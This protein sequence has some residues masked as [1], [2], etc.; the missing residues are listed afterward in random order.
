MF[1]E[2]EYK[3]MGDMPQRTTINVE[4]IAFGNKEALRIRKWENRFYWDSS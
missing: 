3:S 4:K 2:N 1:K